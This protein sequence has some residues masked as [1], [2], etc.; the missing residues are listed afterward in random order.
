MPDLTDL[1]RLLG[2]QRL[3]IADLTAKPAAPVAGT[4]CQDLS[5]RFDD[6]STAR[7][8]RIAPEHPAPTVLY[9]HAHGSNYAIGRDEL[10]QGRSALQGPYGP[11]LAEAGLASIAIDLPCFGS[12]ADQDET[13]LA[14]QSLWHGAP[15]FGRMLAELRAV[16]HWLGTDPK[17]GPIATLGLSM[18]A[19][20]AF[21]LAALEPRIAACAHLACFADLG[22]LV[23]HGTDHLHAPYMMVPGLL[24]VARTGQIAGRIAPRPQLICAGRQD[25]LT[26]PEALDRALM[27][28]SRAY[29][30]ADAT[31]NLQMLIDPDL[32]HAESPEMRAAVLKFLRTALH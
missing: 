12:R 16:F 9:C 22:T 14:R 6:G 11:A 21:W 30:N 29:A 4:A 26:P 5:L 20:H 24:P 23:A 31:A 28:V 19:T 8:W 2:A 10:L 18:G 25:P 13:T 32:G 3:T 7:G 15:L 17:V 27:D 1:H